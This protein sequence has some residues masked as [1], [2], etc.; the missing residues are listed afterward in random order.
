MS[1]RNR[2]C[3]P[4]RTTPHPD[5]QPGPT[6][7]QT[8]FSERGDVPLSGHTVNK[9]RRSAVFLLNIEGLT[10]SKMNILH[11]LAVQYEALVVLLQETQCACADKLT[12][13]GFALAE[14]SLSRKHDL[15]TFVHDRLKWSLVDQSPATSETKW[16]C[17]DVDGYRTV[18]VYKPPPTRLQASDLPV[19]PHP[20]LYA[21]DFNCPHVCWG[22]RTSSADGEC[23]VAW[24]SLNDLVP[25]HEPKDVATFHSGRWNTGTNSDLAFVSVGPDSRVPNR[26]ILETFPR[27][28]HRPSTI[29]RPRLALPVPSKPAKRWNFRKA[30]WSH[31]NT[32]TNKLSKTLLPPDSP[33]VDLAYQDFCKSLE[34]QPKIL[35]HAIVEITTYRVGMLSAI[36]ST[37]HFCSRLKESTLTGLPL[38]CS[39]GSTKNAEIDG[40]RQFR[41]STFCTLAKK[42]IAC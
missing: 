20:V 17:V 25:L 37:V 12:I 36:I 24:S 26:R 39:S 33:D 27:S 16:L 11:Y 32:L 14:S 23:L 18:N 7:R 15:A 34:Q 21:S 28:Q 31:Y 19:F 5:T 42:H 35:S 2:T 13:P 9:F 8:P 1:E 38:P 6:T 3:Q 29:V 40:L 4:G 22:H 41:L 30:N 10:A